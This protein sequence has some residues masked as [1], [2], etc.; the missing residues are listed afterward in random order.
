[1][2]C[3]TV[4]CCALCCANLIITCQEVY[5]DEWIFI[6]HFR[7]LTWKNME[8]SGSTYGTLDHLPE[9][10]WR[11]VNLLTA[12]SITCQ[13]VHRDEW[14]YPRYFR[15][16]SR[17]CMET[18]F[19]RITTMQI[20]NVAILVLTESTCK[21][22]YGTENCRKWTIMIANHDATTIARSFW[23]KIQVLDLKAQFGRTVGW[24]R[25]GS[26]GQNLS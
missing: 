9:S 21:R 4:V 7:A 23:A 14:I 16:L 5:G 2:L 22:L 26:V 6:R 13:K 3:C 12:L 8:M 1:M 24:L 10:A 17:K 15:S 20:F 11:W 19:P 18:S 25:T